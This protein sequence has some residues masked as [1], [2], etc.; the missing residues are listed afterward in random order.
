MIALLNTET[1]PLIRAGWAG[2]VL[3]DD[4]TDNSPGDVV[5]GI[6]SRSWNQ[7]ATVRQARDWY[8]QVCTVVR[9]ASVLE[10]LQGARR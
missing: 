1:L 10:R 2:S 7:R 6:E 5:S 3:S 4:M 8:R 9:R